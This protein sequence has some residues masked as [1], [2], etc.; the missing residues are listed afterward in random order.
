MF[1]KSVSKISSALRKKYSA[2]IVQF[3]S[4][5]RW[6]KKYGW[7]EWSRVSMFDSMTR[8]RSARL[9]VSKKNVQVQNKTNPIG[10]R[11]NRW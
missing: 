4:R 5:Y 7:T 11:K 1:R 8:L 2:R 10:V 6:N 3:C 9:G